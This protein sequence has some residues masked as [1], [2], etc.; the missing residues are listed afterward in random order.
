MNKAV[1]D[2][3]LPR[4]YTLKEAVAAFGSTGLTVKSLRREVYAGRIKVVRS[5]PGRTAKIL[6][7]EDELLRWL[8]EDASQRQHLK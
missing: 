7:R 1:S 6:I 4:L 5:R 3:S 8:D 2:S